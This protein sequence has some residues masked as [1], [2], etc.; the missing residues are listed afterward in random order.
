MAMALIALV[1]A[2]AFLFNSLFGKLIQGDGGVPDLFHCVFDGG[3]R[4]M[5]VC[6]EILVGAVAAVRRLLGRHT[7][8]LFD[9]GEVEVEEERAVEEQEQ[10][11][12]A[13][14]VA[15]ELGSLEG[16]VGVTLDE[17]FATEQWVQGI[18]VA[19]HDE[20]VGFGDVREGRIA[21]DFQE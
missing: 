5:E 10:A 12:A 18:A 14:R 4:Q 3:R 16:Q 20:R 9:E 17:D 1:V 15:R 19:V 8:S 21:L 13:L 7:Q 6:E 2:L 11:S